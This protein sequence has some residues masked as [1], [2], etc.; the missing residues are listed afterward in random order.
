[1]GTAVR[2]LMRGILLGVC[3]AFLLSCS[4]PTGPP[5]P[6]DAAPEIARLSILSEVNRHG[7]LLVEAVPT[8]SSFRLPTNRFVAAIVT[9]SRGDTETIALQRLLCAH[10]TT[11]R[12]ILVWME[13][14][15]LASEIEPEVRG[16]D[17]RMW[18]A[19]GLAGGVWAFGDR[20]S[21]LRRVA[22]LPGVSAAD[23][24]NVV[25]EDSD[26][27]LG[28]LLAGAL[29]FAHNA[30]VPGDGLLTVED[31]DVVEVAYEDEFGVRTVLVL[32]VG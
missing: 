26:V 27:D 11:C 15:H 6:L 1:M 25:P 12:R 28:F 13:D 4:E 8:D 9:T 31:G 29:P 22:A 17:A 32:N 10:R 21:I 2:I 19:Y 5:R 16:A 30:V 3:V 24:E 18:F 14:G 23:F 7:A 20:H